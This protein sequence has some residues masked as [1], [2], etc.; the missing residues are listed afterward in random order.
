MPNRIIREGILDSERIERLVRDAG[1]Q[2][3]VLY[4]RLMSVVD[5]F[6]RFDGRVSVIKARC[7]PTLIDLVRDS[8]LQ[9]LIAACEKAGLIRIYEVTG[10]PYLEVLDFRQFSRAKRSKFPAPDEHAQ[11]RCSADAVHMRPYAE[12]EAYAE[13][14]TNTPI[15]PSGAGGW[16][17]DDG[18]PEAEAKAETYPPGLQRFWD[19]YPQTGKTRSSRKKCFAAWKRLKIEQKAN[20]ILASLALW[21]K[22]QQWRKDGGQFVPAADRWLRDEKWREQP[23]GVKAAAPARNTTAD[24]RAA[25]Q[26]AADNAKVDAAIAAKSDVELS[27]LHKRFLET[28]DPA[29]VPLLRDKDPRAHPVLRAGIYKLITE[30]K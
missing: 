2:A 14:E 20:A 16:F 13:T 22:C 27:E 5:D 11:C 26:L 30:A 6:G 10:K 23:E 24:T 18:E 25:E 19:A 17:G 8:D 21:K 4:R 12:T 3:E 29:G 15:P 28:L 9:R 7:Y 1:W